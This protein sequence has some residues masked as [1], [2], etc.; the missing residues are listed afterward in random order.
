[1]IELSLREK[2]LVLS[3]ADEETKIEYWKNQKTII[4]N[5]ENCR[6]FLFCFPTGAYFDLERVER[7]RADRMN[8]NIIVISTPVEVSGGSSLRAFRS[9]KAYCKKFNTYLLY[10]ITDISVLRK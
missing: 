2:G 4:D 1:M 5:C 8:N 3:K 6:K 10:H 7:Y 9:I